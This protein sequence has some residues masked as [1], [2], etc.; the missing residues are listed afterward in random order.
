MRRSAKGQGKDTV[1][2]P[3]S[4]PASP[5]AVLIFLTPWGWMGISETKKGIDTIVLRK[6]S[7][8]AV[9][10]ALR[11]FGNEPINH[12]PSERLQVAQTQVS[13][14]LTRTRQSFDFPLDLSQ[15]TSFQRLVWR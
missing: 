8:S 7:R 12:R 15:G 11:S 6:P 3:H 10:S 13:E 5:R 4:S 14:Y 1:P 2:S 9:E